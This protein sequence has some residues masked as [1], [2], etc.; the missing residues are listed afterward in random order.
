M[1]VKD[2]CKQYGLDSSAFQTWL[3]SSGYEY[4]TG[5]MGGVDITDSQDIPAIVEHF[6]REQAEQQEQAAQESAAQH[7]ALQAKQQALANMIITPGHNFDGYTIT[8]YSGYISG[9]HAVEIARGTEFFGTGVTKVGEALMSALVDIRRQ[10]L[11]EL[12]EAAYALG[13]NAIIGVDFDY[14]T[15]QPE[16]ANTKGEIKL[17]PYVF[18]VTANGNAV[19]IERN[20]STGLV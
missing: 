13:C 8:R 15:L 17:L 12:K 2:V 20:R 9:D 18:G 19:V 7:E 3:W 16:V 1:K 5:A 14:L 4:K 6:R 11:L 10:A